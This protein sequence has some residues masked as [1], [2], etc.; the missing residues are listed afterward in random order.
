MKQKNAFIYIHINLSLCWEVEIENNRLRQ[1]ANIGC[2]SGKIDLRLD[3][4]LVTTHYICIIVSS[5]QIHVD[6]S[7]TC[8]I[9]KK[10]REDQRAGGNSLFLRN[11]HRELLRVWDSGTNHWKETLDQLLI[12]SQARFSD[13]AQPGFVHIDDSNYSYYIAVATSLR[14]DPEYCKVDVYFK[15]F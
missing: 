10:L 9:I 3:V 8:P 12:K 14:R 15:D 11:C 6:M 2:I 7:S 5:L 1:T 4:V 13:V